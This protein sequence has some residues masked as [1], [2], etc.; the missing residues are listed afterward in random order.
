M[1]VS[2]VKH[3]QRVGNRSVLHQD[4]CCKLAITLITR[5]MS[6]IRDVTTATRGDSLRPV[7]QTNATIAQGIVG[8][9]RGSMIQPDKESST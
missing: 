1:H 5:S 8:R 2:S 9:A 7:E 4:Y 3:V 6:S